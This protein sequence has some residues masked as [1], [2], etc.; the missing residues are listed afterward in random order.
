LKRSALLLVIFGCAFIR[1]ASSVR[2]HR[3]D[4]STDYSESAALTK[5]EAEL[6]APEVGVPEVRPRL[7]SLAS[8]ICALSERI[9]ELKSRKPEDEGIAF[10]CHDSQERCEKALR[11]ASERAGAPCLDD[12]GPQNP[13]MDL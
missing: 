3:A 10:A 5:L 11:Y 1:C 2:E 9:C 8:Q 7:C 13:V 12:A 6:Y 4:Y